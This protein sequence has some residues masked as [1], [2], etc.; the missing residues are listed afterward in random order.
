M[1]GELTW[2]RGRKN[3]LGWR[4]GTRRRRAPSSSQHPSLA[5]F[6]S[7]S[8]PRVAVDFQAVSKLYF[9]VSPR[10]H[11]PNLQLDMQMGGE[12]GGLVGILSFSLLWPRRERGGAVELSGQLLKVSQESLV[13]C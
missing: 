8:A 11:P 1:W 12:K 3:S 13:S 7:L 4:S 10:Y 9:S 5:A 2:G 6:K